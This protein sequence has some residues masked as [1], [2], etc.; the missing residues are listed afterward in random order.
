[1]GGAAVA[2]V[3]AVLGVQTWLNSAPALGPPRLE[4][5]AVSANGWPA[6]PQ[7]LTDW[8]PNFAGALLDASRSYTEPGAAPA[9][10][11]V[12]VWV[13]YYRDQK[14]GRKLVTS[15]NTLVDAET[16]GAWSQAAGG[17]AARVDLAGRPQALVAAT[18][19]GS[20]DVGALLA[21]RLR[22]W[23]VYWVGGQLITSGTRARL[24]LAVNR[25]MGRGDDG[26]ALFFYTPLPGAADGAAQAEKTLSAFVAAELPAL[27]SSL[28]AARKSAGT[29]P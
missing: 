28:D 8:R 5:A 3:L 11:Q 4:L 7:P 22:V 27:L 20:A 10:R 26:A 6:A 18:L 15:T 1:V 25:L 21:P 17:Q 12:A 16:H 23:Q 14:G 24:Q 13:A 29:A 19:R 2:L 9:G